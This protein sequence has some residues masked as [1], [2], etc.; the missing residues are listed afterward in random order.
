[1]SK[2]YADSIRLR[3]IKTPV[4]LRPLGEKTIFLDRED[5][6]TKIGDADGSAKEVVLVGV[7]V[8]SVSL[9]SPD[10]SVWTITINNDGQLIATKP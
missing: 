4:A 8:D 5:G 3:P 7:G 2:I 9:R 6:K 10:S 1:M